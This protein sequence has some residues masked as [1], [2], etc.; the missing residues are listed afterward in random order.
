[1]ME[2]PMVAP[3]PVVRDHA[4]V[5]CAMVDNHGQCRH[6]QHYLT[7]MIILPNNSMANIARCILESADTSGLGCSRQPPIANSDASRS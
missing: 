4:V 6:V 2:L 1:M 3:A 7:G 5:C